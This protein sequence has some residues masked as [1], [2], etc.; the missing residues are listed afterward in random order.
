[1]ASNCNEVFL[2]SLY[3]NDTPTTSAVMSPITSITSST[4]A[5][6]SLFKLEIYS[7]DYYTRIM[8][9]GVDLTKELE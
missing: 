9:N 2:K 4:H 3:N 8:A 7:Y 5:N 6:H 1:M